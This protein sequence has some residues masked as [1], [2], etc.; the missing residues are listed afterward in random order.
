MGVLITEL[1]LSRNLLIICFK[2]WKVMC[3]EFNGFFIYYSVVKHLGSSQSTQEAGGKHPTTSRVSRTLLL[4]SSCFLLLYDKKEH[5]QGFFYLLN[6]PTLQLFISWCYNK[7]IQPKPNEYRWYIAQ[8]FLIGSA[9]AG[10][11]EKAEGSKPIR[12]GQIF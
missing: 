6:N 12:N 10:Y 1:K 9:P 8:N 11:E 4:G 2:N 5:R 3:G 7:G